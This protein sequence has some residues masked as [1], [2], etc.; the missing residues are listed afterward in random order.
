MQTNQSYNAQKNLGS[1][2][3]EAV[4]RHMENKDVISGSQHG[5]TEGKSCL[6]IWWPPMMGLQH[7]WRREK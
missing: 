5:F 6:Q 4:L 3:L 2:P 7:W 1:N